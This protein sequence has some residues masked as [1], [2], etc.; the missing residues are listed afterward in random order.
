MKRRVFICSLIALL[1]L[2]FTSGVFAASYQHPA[3]GLVFPDTL[4]S[5]KK[6]EF[7][8]YEKRQ[9][10]LGIGVS[11]TA[12]GIAANI[13]VYNFGIRDFPAGPDEPAMKKHFEQVVGDVVNFGK[14]GKYL[15]LKQLS[16][17]EVVLGPSPNGPRALSASFSFM[18][19][20]MDSVSSLYLISYKKHFIKVRYTYDKKVKDKGDAILARLL[21][22]LA[23][24]MQK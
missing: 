6:G 3:T 2:L 22:E 24:M 16:E 12:S 4:A 19:N 10:G 17:K 14:Q 5:L 20:K 18:V 8:D 21:N 1:L 15:N 23:A 7:T 9:R 11:Y 13:F